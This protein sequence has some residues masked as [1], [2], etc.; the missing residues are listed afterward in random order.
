MNAHLSEA[1]KHVVDYSIGVA[2]VAFVLKMLPLITGVLV[3]AL[4]VLRLAIGV[5]EFKLNRRKLGK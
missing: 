1:G 4:C 3:L 2:G 5:Q